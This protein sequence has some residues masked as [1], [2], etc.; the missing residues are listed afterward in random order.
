MESLQEISSH[1]LDGKRPDIDPDVDR[2]IP[3]IYK[4]IMKKAWD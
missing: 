1:V 4:K 2:K 3:I